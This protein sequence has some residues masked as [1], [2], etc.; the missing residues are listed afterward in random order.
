MLLI[1]NEV[2]KILDMKKNRN[3]VVIIRQRWISLRLT[4]SEA[5]S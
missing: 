5:T 1:M 3:K 4:R 2:S